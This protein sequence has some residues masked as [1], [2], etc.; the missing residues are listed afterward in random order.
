MV[1]APLMLWLLACVRSGD[2]QN[3]L[4]LLVDC[5]QPQAFER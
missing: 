5:A 1:C 4:P 2:L 3:L